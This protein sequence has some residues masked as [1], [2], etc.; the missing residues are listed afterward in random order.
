MEIGLPFEL[1]GPD[2]C[3]KYSQSAHKTESSKQEAHPCSPRRRY[4]QRRYSPLLR[5]RSFYHLALTTT[6][7]HN[8]CIRTHISVSCFV[9]TFH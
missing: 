8:A 5:G 6:A 4:A 7:R 2:T 3:V 1:F 9:N